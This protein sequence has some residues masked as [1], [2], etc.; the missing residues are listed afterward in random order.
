M[1]FGWIPGAR[2]TMAD[3][4]R[5][6]EARRVAGRPSL[7]C[8]IVWWSEWSE[9]YNTTWLI[10]RHGYLTPERFRHKRLQQVAAAA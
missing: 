2:W 10:G 4:D 6:I 7:F 5:G 8:R 3:L 9:V 1:R